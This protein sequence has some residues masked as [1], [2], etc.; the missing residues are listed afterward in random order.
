MKWIIVLRLVRLLKLVPRRLLNWFRVHYT[1]R[2]WECS[3]WLDTGFYLSPVFQVDCL[4]WWDLKLG[5]DVAGILSSDVS[6]RFGFDSCGCGLGIRW[7]PERSMRPEFHWGWIVEGGCWCQFARKSDLKQG[8]GRLEVGNGAEGCW[9]NGD[10][11]QSS[12]GGGRE[13]DG[14]A[15]KQT[16]DFA[17]R[18]LVSLKNS[19]VQVNELIFLRSSKETHN[20]TAEKRE[21]WKL[22]FG[23]WKN[24][25]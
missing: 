3:R 9:N 25:P 1:S 5:W 20:R 16:R 8:V 15:V 14:R 21:M 19:S 24:S 13:S 6:L 11:S 10:G 22:M 7:R 4:S 17:Y 12:G 18:R 23:T 2:F